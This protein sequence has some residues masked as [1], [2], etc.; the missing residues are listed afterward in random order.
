VSWRPTVAAWEG[1]AGPWATWARTRGH[2][3]HYELL[4]LPQFLKLLPAPGRLTVDVG[5]GE[6]RLGRALA[7]NGH[8]VIG[9][10]SSPT[11]V[12][13]ARDGGGHREVLEASAQAIPLPDGCAELVTAFMSLHD[14]DDLD[15]A[16]GEAARLLGRGGHLCFAVPH[17]FA[18]M[19][20]ERAGA[21]GYFT[22]HRYAD[23]VERDGVRMTFE[24]WRRPLSGYTE[25]LERAGFV[26]EALRE[27]AP[28]DSALSAA[29]GLAKW[30][31]Q[32]L[33]LQVRAL[34][35]SQ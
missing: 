15:G 12:R 26:I 24:S 7:G 28:D 18:E 29:P 11:L 10:D 30:R 16:F 9:V 3:Y 31:E 1:H 34:L 23:V 6:G 14:M 19:N 8:A 13:L 22:P 35:T 27:P 33:F 4:N 17:P 20:R 2:D 25:A 21:P 5:C 32:P